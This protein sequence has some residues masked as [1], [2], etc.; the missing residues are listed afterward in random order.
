MAGQDNLHIVRESFAAWNAH[1][2]E[3]FVKRLDTKTI[4]ESDTFPA[5]FV[6]HEGARQFFKLYLTA[7]ETCPTPISSSC[8]IASRRPPR[9]ARSKPQS[10]PGD[11]QVVLSRH[12]SLPCRATRVPSSP[13]PPAP[14]R[15]AC[16]FRGTSLS[17][18]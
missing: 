11:V 18:W 15:S 13:L 3:A 1:D 7:L 14:A 9:R 6:G 17:R 12:S 2:V 10:S 16:P 5:P 4:W 8:P